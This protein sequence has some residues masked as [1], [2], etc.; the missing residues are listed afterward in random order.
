MKSR[1][2]RIQRK[3]DKFL[4]Y[5]KNHIAE[6]DD[7][8]PIDLT[9][10]R[11][12]EKEM[13][14]PVKCSFCSKEFKLMSSGTVILHCNTEETKVVREML[15]NDDAFIMYAFCSH[16]CVKFLKKSVYCHQ[17]NN[18][19]STSHLFSSAEP[20]DKL[21][22]KINDK[23]DH[24]YDLFFAHFNS[25]VLKIACSA[26]CKSK[27]QK[28]DS[29][30]G[31]LEIKIICGSC[32]KRKDKMPRCPCGNIYFC[33]TDCQKNM[34]P[35]HKETCVWHLNKKLREERAKKANSNSD[36]K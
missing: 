11:N 12:D 23:Y 10:T 20:S 33:D 27:I 13:Y 2:A 9:A 6:T 25:H 26:I 3:A 22:C 35:L 4:P 19:V 14:K 18:I 21:N 30:I 32:G 29:K 15:Q 24:L 31:E 1:D 34:W 16:D 28:E 8:I 7:I 36:D 17:C 5:I